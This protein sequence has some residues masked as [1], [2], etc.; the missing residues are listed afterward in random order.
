MH[1]QCS[2]GASV[3][4]NVYRTSSGVD[5]SVCLARFTDPSGAIEVWAPDYDQDRLWLCDDHQQRI[6]LSKEQAR[7]LRDYLTS[8][9]TR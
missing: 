4:R 9:L 1:H 8:L 7:M 5:V 3:E 6:D 2:G